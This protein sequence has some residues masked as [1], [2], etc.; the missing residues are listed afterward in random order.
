MRW[1]PSICPDRHSGCI[2]EWASGSTWTPDEPWWF[3][4]VCAVHD[5]PTKQETLAVLQSESQRVSYAREA[6]RIALSIPDEE[7]ASIVFRFDADRRLTLTV[8][9]ASKP[10]LEANRAAVLASAQVHD[11]DVTI[12]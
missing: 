11:P 12:E 2:L 7:A 3:V 9:S 1:R 4:H 6:V 5:R 10:S 8:P